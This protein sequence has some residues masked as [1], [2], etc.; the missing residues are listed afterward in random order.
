MILIGK[1]ETPWQ[2][3]SP[4]PPSSTNQERSDGQQQGKTHILRFC[5]FGGKCFG[6]FN[7][8]MALCRR[9]SKA[10]WSFDAA[11][12]KKLKGLELNGKVLLFLY[13]FFTGVSFIL[14]LEVRPRIIVYQQ[15]CNRERKHFSFLQRHFQQNLKDRGFGGGGISHLVL[16]LGH[17]FL[18]LVLLWTSSNSQCVLFPKMKMSKSFNKSYMSSAST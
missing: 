5:G 14:Q 4:V 17:S 3:T 9:A 16:W 2:I 13:V 18:R 11:F 7:W 10:S 12:Q 6:R 1:I 15:I 8:T